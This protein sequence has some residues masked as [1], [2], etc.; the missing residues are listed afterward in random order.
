VRDLLTPLTAADVLTASE[1]A[2]LLRMPVST[3]HDY[4]RRGVLPSTKIGRHRLYVRSRI[5]A[6]LLGETAD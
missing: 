5:E 1:V 2:A 6:T 3:V 4:A